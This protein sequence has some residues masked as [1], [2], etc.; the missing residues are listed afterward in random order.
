MH[1]LP[2]AEIGSAGASAACRRFLGLL[3]LGRAICC[4]RSRSQRCGAMDRRSFIWRRTL[5]SGLVASVL[6]RPQSRGTLS[7]AGPLPGQ[8]VE[9]ASPGDLPVEQPTKFELIV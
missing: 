3:P 1:N 4:V 5:E 8:S 7:E 9:G 6:L 2:G